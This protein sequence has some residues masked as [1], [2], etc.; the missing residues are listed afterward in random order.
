MYHLII[1]SMN[2]EVVLQSDDEASLTD[3]LLAGPFAGYVT[4]SEGNIHAIKGLS[5]F[6]GR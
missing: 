6:I 1:I 2:K 4:D 3:M 5:K